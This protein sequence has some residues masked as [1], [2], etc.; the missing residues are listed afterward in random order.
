MTRNMK[1][2]FCF[3]VILLVA[4]S[5]DDFLNVLPENNLSEEAFFSSEKDMEIY[6]NG[7]LQRY[8][9]DD[10][11]VAFADQYADYVATR[12]STT[13]LKGD[14]WR[15]EDQ[16]GWSWGQLRDANW[17]LDNIVRAKDLVPA[18]VYN[19]YVG[20]GRFWRA[21]FYYNMVKTFGNVPWYDHELDKDETDQ[22]YKGRDS[23]QFV[24]DRVLED[25]SF[26]STYCSTDSKIVTSSTRIS[27]WVALAFK[28]RV[29]LFEGTYRKYHTELGLT[30]SAGRFLQEAVAACE[31]LIKE[32]PYRLETAGDVK[33]RYRSL[34]NSETLNTNEVILGVVFRTNVR[35]HDLTWKSF[36]ASYGAGWS[37]TKQ[38]VNQYLMLDGTRF[39]DRAGYQ[40]TPYTEEFKN[41]DYRL[42]QT[43]ISPDY[44][45][46]VNGANIKV[47]PNFTM[48]FTGYQ[49]IK[50]AIDDEVHVGKATSANSLP[51]FRYAEVL[52]NCAEAKAELGEMDETVWNATIRPVRERAGV[53]G[54]AP[55]A[56][57]S[58]LAA[59]Y[60]NQT[61]DRWILEVRRERAVELAFEQLRY[62]D[63]MRWKMG[64]LIEMPW[65]GVYIDALDKGYDLNGDGSIDLTVSRTSA[66]SATCVK[67]DD[68]TFSLTGGTSGNLVYGQHQG[69]MWIDKKYL[70]P[71]P[72]SAAQVNPNLLPQNAGWEN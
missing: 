26:A 64:E 4:V 35:M 60:R 48:N 65:Q 43:V 66:S 31:T 62:D 47:A 13:F 19:H 21:Y 6:A 54:S 44:Q 9:P 12:A 3:A 16:G 51:L 55:V 27:R 53:D 37:L 46:K 8:L 63:L 67:L 57:D 14:S 28:A 45:R 36:S 5:C 7:F 18:D 29:C 71:V 39:T 61:T 58:Y 56:Y 22:L 20:V 10:D 52:L 68:A 38:F 33:T 69:R 49:L 50:W 40:T 59:Y 72:A 15:P 23:R 2:I 34:F 17:F 70:R 30:A 24:M 1:K 11:G 41:R 25:L 32:S 42:Q